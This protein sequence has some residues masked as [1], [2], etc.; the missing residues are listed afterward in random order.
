MRYFKLLPEVA[1][2]IGKTS[3]IEYKNGHLQ[4]V[5][6]LEYCFEDWL[7]GEIL[8]SHPCF[9]V[10]KSLEKDIVA[11]KLKGV[12]FRRI[13][14]SLSDEF[15]ELYGGDIC[16]PTFDELICTKKFE[17]RNR[18]ENNVFYRDCH[19]DLIVSERALLVLKRHNLST[20]I[21]IECQEQNSGQYGRI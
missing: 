15:L 11:E 19:Q 21:I 4:T 10:T 5:R 13:S 20:S 2:G 6:H 9:I 18:F 14:V 12:S 16:L 1:G 7:G 17:D 8:S 3:D